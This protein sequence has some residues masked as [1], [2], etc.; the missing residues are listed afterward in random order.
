M[1]MKKAGNS[2]FWQ[3]NSFVWKWFNIV[4]SDE[5]GRKYSLETLYEAHTG[6]PFDELGQ[7]VPSYSEMNPGDP[8]YWL[9]ANRRFDF[10]SFVGQ[11]DITDHFRWQQY[12]LDQDGQ[13]GGFLADGT[14][15]GLPYD[16][17]TNADAQFNQYGNNEYGVP[18]MDWSTGPYDMPYFSYDSSFSTIRRGKGFDVTIRYGQGAMQAG[19]YNWGWRV[20]P[21]RINWIETYADGQM[22]PSGAP[23]DWRFGHRW[24]DVDADLIG[25]DNAIAQLGDHAPEKVIYTALVA[26]GDSAATQADVDAFAASVDGMMDFLV[27]REGLPPTPDVAGFPVAS[28]DINFLFSGLDMYADRTTIA[29]AGKGSWAEDDVI[30]ITVHND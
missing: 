20:H 11:D 9:Y 12:D 28:S 15:T 19:I 25:L 30:S 17:S 3:R 14:D 4:D 2:L 18:M 5:D 16:A 8:R 6:T 22:L 29:A 21:P 10:G 7:P 26:F 13:I 1:I 24:D 27:R 23:K